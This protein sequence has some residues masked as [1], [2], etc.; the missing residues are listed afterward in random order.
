[1]DLEVERK[2]IKD[3]IDNFMKQDSENKRNIIGVF[4]LVLSLFM[5]YIIDT[6]FMIKENVMINL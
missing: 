6:K 2:R 1:M 3:V 5:T 4:I